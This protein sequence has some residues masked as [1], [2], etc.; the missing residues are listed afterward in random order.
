MAHK[1][2]L[3]FH[4]QIKLRDKVTTAPEPVQYIVLCAAGTVDVPECLAGQVLDRAVVGGV[5][6]RM[7]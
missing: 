5:S 2:A 1:F 4:D 7:V 3:Y 6:V